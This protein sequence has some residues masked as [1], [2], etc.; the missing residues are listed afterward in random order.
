VLEQ[1]HEQRDIRAD[2]ENGVL[3]QS[4]ERAMPCGLPRLATGDQFREH[5]IVVDGHVGTLGYAGIDA[6]SRH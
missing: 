4:S 3:T 5:R 2:A 6:N 1:R